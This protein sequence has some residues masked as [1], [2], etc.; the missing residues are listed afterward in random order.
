MPVLQRYSNS[1]FGPFDVPWLHLAGIAG[2]GLL[3]ALLAA[4]VPAFLASRQDV[5]AVLAG[6]R[7]D[8]APSLRSPVLGVV[9]LGAGIALSAYG[10]SASTN[11]EFLIAGAAIVVV[12]GMILV[13]PVVVVLVARLAR[14]LPLAVRY[15][16]RDTSRHRTR[17]VPAVAAVAA[18]V[19]GVVALGIGVT[20]DE[21]ENRGAYQAT[22][23]L[24]DALVAI[25]N[26]A[27]DPATVT[28]IIR[29]ALPGA[30][31]VPVSGVQESL[32]DGGYRMVS[33][34]AVGGPENLLDT[35]GGSLAS[36]VL[37]SDG[38]V[39]PQV[40]G[41]SRSEASRV[42]QVLAEGGVVVFTSRD[43][44][45][46]TVRI[47]VEESDAEG[48]PVGTPRTVE[49]P[50]LFVRAGTVGPQGILATAVAE[51]LETEAVPVG[52]VVSGV[53]ITR[54]AEKDVEEALKAE[55]DGTSFYVERGYRT[56][57][58][59]LVIQLILAGL[60]AVLMLGGTLTA[61]FLALSD[62]RPDL[63]TL[64]AVG[65]A[66]RSRRGVA[67]SY[68]LVVGGVGAV[69]GA[70]VGFIPGIA[71]SYP[72]TTQYGACTFSGSGLTTCA[73]VPG[74]SHYLDIPWAFIIG[75]V[76]VLPL[77]TALIVGLTARSQ[78]PLVARLD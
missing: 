40:G 22:L 37:V 15:A 30:S 71:I 62:A 8:R 11:G 20:S 41:L 45:A 57:G 76:I 31:A 54:D 77:L 59:T 38:D 16:V 47:R 7:G 34:R 4:V 12:L 6:R 75:L 9:L 58:E 48:S 26:P 21:A 25:G 74:P 55:T 70:A 64:S 5:V 60:G 35:Y 10:A 24:G 33:F 73:E 27:T 46:D 36:S 61:T 1:T 53:N 49:T 66:P 13:V 43:V 2:F 28:G 65:A 17:T 56:D 18:T 32:A 50:A 63:A 68:A 39:P 3:S 78:L 14:G 72:L 52:V 44:A 69:V 67:A 51:K 42:D 19:A 23:P 29:D